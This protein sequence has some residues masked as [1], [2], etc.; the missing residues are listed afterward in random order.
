MFVSPV[1]IKINKY[2]GT[3]K[4]DKRLK[5]IAKQT[6]I[7]TICFELSPGG[8]HASIEAKKNLD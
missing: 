4:N 2:I 8:V 5:R 7:T 3:L 6:K 1:V